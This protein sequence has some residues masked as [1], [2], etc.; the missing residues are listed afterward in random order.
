[1]D[2]LHEASD[3]SVPRSQDETLTSAPLPIEQSLAKGM[4]PKK[5]HE[6]EQ[7]ASL[8]DRVARNAQCDFLMDLG[9]GLVSACQGCHS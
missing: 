8:V 6:V 2:F 5:R 7:M 9:S 3:L 4:N 1:M